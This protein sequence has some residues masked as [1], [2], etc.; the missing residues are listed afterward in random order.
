MTTRV[1]GDNAG[2]TTGNPQKPVAPPPKRQSPV[3]A[4]LAIALGLAA[5]FLILQRLGML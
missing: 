3:K 1:F 4:V 2:F 5:A